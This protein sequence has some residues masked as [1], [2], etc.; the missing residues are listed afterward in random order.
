MNKALP[1][2]LAITLVLGLNACGIFRRKPAN[3]HEETSAAKAALKDSGVF[4]HIGPIGPMPDSGLA[5]GNNPSTETAPR[6]PALL[7]ALLPHARPD[8]Q[9]QTF[10]SRADAHF[11][12]AGQSHDFNA[13]IRME[14]GKK[15]WISATALLNFEVARLLITPDSVW[16]INRLTRS[17]FALPFAKMDELLPLKA[18]FESLQSLI[19]GEPM[20][21]RQQPNVAKDTS[22]MLVLAYTS[23]ELIQMLQF[24][25]N[26]T[27][28]QLQYL[29]SEK[30]SMSCAYSNPGLKD[31]HHF[32]ASWRLRIGD[33]GNLYLLNLDFRKVNF[34]AA[35]EFPF[36]IPDSYHRQ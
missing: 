11:D 16:L 34:D 21:M 22:N 36:S 1:S 3:K 13:N 19:L 17:V 33:Q 31:G 18:D 30:S 5:T 14:R 2:L 26:D 6:L 25:K 27:S 20:P 32:P 4:V 12:G 15:I 7:Q 8:D 9:W 23:P 29:S 24:S 10:S 28:L 35:T